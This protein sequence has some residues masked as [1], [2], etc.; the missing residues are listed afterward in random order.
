MSIPELPTLKRQIYRLL[1]VEFVLSI[2]I[3]LPS[4]LPNLGGASLWITPAGCL[5]GVV[6][7]STLLLLS[8]SRNSSPVPP[9]SHLAT[10]ICTSLLGLVFT[11]GFGLALAIISI[12]L[13]EGEFFKPSDGA[14]F[15]E[16][17]VVGTQIGILVTIAIKCGQQRRGT[18]K[19]DIELPIRV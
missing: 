2:V 10:I 13:V 1:W 15:A 3:L 12:I 11:A 6:H 19:E 8:K 4:L 14:V 9:T 5:L 16:L 17:V 18:M 7:S